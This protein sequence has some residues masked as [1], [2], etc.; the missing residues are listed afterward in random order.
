MLF[1]YF[2]KGQQ[3]YISSAIIA[4]SGGAYERAIK[5]INVA[6]ENEDVLSA[7]EKSKAYFY[8]G[9]STIKLYESD[10][11]EKLPLNPYLKAF[12]DFNNVVSFE[13]SLWIIRAQ[14]ELSLL[15]GG[16]KKDAIIALNQSKTIADSPRK[17]NFI[18]R[19][20][21]HLNAAKM[22]NQ[23]FEI[24]KLLGDVYL[25]FGDYYLMQDPERSPANYRA[26]LRFYELSFR[27]NNDCELC[28]DGLIEVAIN[29]S[30]SNLQ[31]KYE[32]IKSTF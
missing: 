17:R 28:I 13:D 11:Q 19:A 15:F 26:A 16:L 5:D 24:D 12:T 20:L 1:S 4:F 7:S 14:K 6:L 30:D 18:A 27:E 21:N 29:L 9:L 32:Q 2:S 22:I 10:Q 8:R 3:R 23:D 25:A 31:K